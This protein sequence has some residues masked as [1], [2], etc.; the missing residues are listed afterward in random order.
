MGGLCEA[1]TFDVD[2]VRPVLGKAFTGLAFDTDDNELDDNRR[3]WI[4]AVFTDAH[5]LDGASVDAGDFVV[6]GHTVQKVMW[7][8]EDGFVDT[9]TGDGPWSIRK[10]V[11][12]QLADELN[13]DETPTVFL[14]PIAGGISD[15]A[16][17]I[18]NSDQAEARDRIG[19]KFVVSN[20]L[21]AP[22]SSSLVGEEVQVTFTITADDG[23]EEDSG[24]LIAVHILKILAY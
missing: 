2:T 14:I 4:L 24:G 21:P 7:F 16:G 23:N 15:V 3:D 9:E 5:D 13:S 19:P 6:E 11:F 20:F 10:L 12:I 18:N 1:N 22:S 17:N 8:D